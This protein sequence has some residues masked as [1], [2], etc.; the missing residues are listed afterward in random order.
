[1]HVPISMNLDVSPL[2]GESSACVAQLYTLEKI[3]AQSRVG[4]TIPGFSKHTHVS[5]SADTQQEIL[6]KTQN[7]HLS[8]QKG[9]VQ[10]T[11]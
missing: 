3:Y 2:D 5:S 7:V 11:H 6:V 10:F 4:K 9:K 1:M 8:Q